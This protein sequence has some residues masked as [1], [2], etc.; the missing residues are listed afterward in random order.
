MSSSRQI[1]N[2]FSWLEL[3]NYCPDG[4]NGDF[5]FFGS[6]LTDTFCFV[7]L[8]NLVL[9]IRTIFFGFTHC[10]RWLREFGLI[11]IILW[12]RKSWLDNFSHPWCAI[13]CKYEWINFRD[14]LLISRGANNG[15]QNALEKKNIHFILWVSHHFQLFYFTENLEFCAIFERSKR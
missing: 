15:S 2:I 9:Y 13:K 4:G 7:K 12:N 8:K 3:L 11:F 14:I 10:D 6:F 5:Q 1:F